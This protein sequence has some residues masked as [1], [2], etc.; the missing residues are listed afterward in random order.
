[1]NV[2]RIII[3]IHIHTYTHAYTYTRTH[4]HI[5]TCTYTSTHA[6][7]RMYMVIG[8]KASPW[9]I[10]HPPTYNVFVGD[11]GY[12]TQL[13]AYSWTHLS[14]VIMFYIDRA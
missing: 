2:L 9:H 14:S 10:S 7:T 1:M 3:H 12:T 5:H 8:L 4:L 13:Y 6:H 11:F